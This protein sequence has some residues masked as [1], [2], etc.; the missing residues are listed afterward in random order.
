VKEQTQL[1][2]QARGK[3]QAEVAGFLEISRP[4]FIAIEKGDRAAKSAEI[5]KLAAYLGRKVH[6][7][8][9][10]TEPVG[11][12]DSRS[13]VREPFAD[14][15]VGRNIHGSSLI[16]PAWQRRHGPAL[17]EPGRWARIRRT[18]PKRFWHSSGTGYS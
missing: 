5:I 12:S 1:L 17:T 8:V 13:L 2:R 10:P 15:Q 16:P 18:R 4:T 7:L 6:E 14:S 11:F 3:T 9:R